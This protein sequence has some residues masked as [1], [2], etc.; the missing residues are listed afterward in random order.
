MLKKVYRGMAVFRT[1]EGVSVV[2]VVSESEVLVMF[3]TWDV[4]DTARNISENINYYKF[5]RLE[6]ERKGRN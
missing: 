5:G 6:K 4:E 1:E 3:V 2:K